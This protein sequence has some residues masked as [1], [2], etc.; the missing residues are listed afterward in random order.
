MKYKNLLLLMLP[1]AC[2]SCNGQNNQQR[3]VKQEKIDQTPSELYGMPK[4]IN[5]IDTSAGFN[6]TGQKLLLTG[7]VFKVDGKTPAP[8]VVIYYYQTNTKGAY[9]HKADE[10]RS[11]PPNSEGQTHGYIRGWVK[12]DKDGKYAIYTIRPAAYATQDSPA[13]IHPIIIEPNRNE[14]YY[15]DDFV[16]DD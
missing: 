16:F 10:P 4:M 15:I 14:S 13:H 6:L 3:F 8:N 2:F 9:E 7:T 11:I 1:L 5:S 12:T